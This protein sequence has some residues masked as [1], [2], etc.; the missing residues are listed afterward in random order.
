M[1]LTPRPYQIHGSKFL[2]DS[3]RAALWDVPGLGKT[4]QAAQA[5]E[6]PALVVCP[7]YLMDHWAE[8][9]ISQ[10]GES[11][12]NVFGS[13]KRREYFLN[14]SVRADWTIVNTEMMRSYRMPL[15]K[16]LII[17][18]AHHFRGHTA[19][20]SLLMAEYA[21]GVHRV[22]QLT[23][24]PQM[25]TVDD[26]Y[27]QMHILDP[28]AFRSWWQFVEDYCV[29]ANTPN[30]IKVIRTKNALGLKLKLRGYAIR[31][32]YKDVGLQLPDLIEQPLL[33]Q[34]PVHAKKLYTDVLTKYRIG[35]V[36]ID[37]PGE[38]IATLRAITVCE[39]KLDALKGLIEDNNCSCVVFCW[40]RETAHIIGTK[41]NM[42][43]ITGDMAP[44]ERV[45]IAKARHKAIVATMPS[46]AEGVDLSFAKLII[47]FECDYTPGLMYQALKRV[48]RYTEDLTPMRAYYLIMRDTIDDVIYKQKTN[49]AADARLI[50]KEALK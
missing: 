8:F 29:T 31:R 24:S 21:K 17:D 33:L 19:Q 26:L 45:K 5:A 30:G 46:L 42:P 18:E 6:R 37:N 15:V 27:M 9:V 50:L 44:I 4:L 40:Y 48:H 32:T 22:Y 7:T 20:Q 38:M 34:L 25:K 28:K 36:P 41:L 2:S 39:E 47:F 43:V 3:R 1:T 49:R 10:Y 35:N 11:V 16:T 14:K 12:Y 23:A 13:R